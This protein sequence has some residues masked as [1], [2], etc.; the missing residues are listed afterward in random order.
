MASR[1]QRETAFGRGINEEATFRDADD[2]VQ[3]LIKKLKAT[4]VVICLTDKVNFRKQVLPTYKMNRADTE[5]PELLQATKDFLADK[6]PSFIRPTLEADDVMGILATNPVLIGGDKIIVSEDKDMR[7]IPARVYNPNK[8]QLGVLNISEF[9]ADLFHLWQTI[10]G[11]M[12]D[13]Y[14]GAKGVGKDSVYADEVLEAESLVEAWEVVLDAYASKGLTEWDA[15]T[16]ARCA[17]ILRHCDYN[18]KTKE[19]ILWEPPT[20]V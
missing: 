16:Q 9:D 6:Y 15:V 2:V 10:V 20:T 12:T 13:G 11:D 17:R 3:G 5:K 4:G 1:N 19:P 8:P 14:A 18:Y 7:T